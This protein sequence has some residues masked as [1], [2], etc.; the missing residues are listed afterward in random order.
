MLLTTVQC[1]GQPSKAKDYPVPSVRSCEVEKLCLSLACPQ[2]IPGYSRGALL[3]G[4]G[5]GGR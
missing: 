2:V 5:E 3:L 4:E 1:T